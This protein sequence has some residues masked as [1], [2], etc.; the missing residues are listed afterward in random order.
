MVL[1][2]HIRLTRRGVQFFL[3]PLTIHK[4]RVSLYF[5]YESV[6]YWT[7]VL[8][9]FILQFMYVYRGL[10]D[11]KPEFQIAI[12]KYDESKSRKPAINIFF[13]QIILV[14]SL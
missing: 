5:F 13:A 9:K 14:L 11:I 1:I 4:S 12:V 10:L 8:V 3:F 2:S 6:I 7:V